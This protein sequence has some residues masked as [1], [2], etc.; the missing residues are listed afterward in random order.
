MAG[1]DDADE[2][3]RAAAKPAAESEKEAKN[4][5]AYYEALT[6]EI[7]AKET[8]EEDIHLRRVEHLLE[9]EAF[10]C[11]QRCEQYP[12]GSKERFW[13][14]VECQSGFALMFLW[15][16]L[17][18]LIGLAGI[19]LTWN[20][21]LAQFLQPGWLHALPG[22]ET[23]F[24]IISFTF[25]AGFIG[26]AAYSFC[27]LYMHIVF[28][29]GNAFTASDDQSSAKDRADESKEREQNN[30]SA[31]QNRRFLI[32][33]EQRRFSGESRTYWAFR[34]L[35]SGVGGVFSYL[36]F[37]LLTAIYT[38]NAGATA[39]PNIRA[40]VGTAFISGAFFGDFL[41]FLARKSKDLFKDKTIATSGGNITNPEPT[42][43]N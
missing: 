10:T 7:D 20:G 29:K 33:R 43:K 18:M 19:Y 32:R 12:K 25:F 31:S 39:A 11:K 40:F 8:A 3:K 26:G 27:A 21:S 4:T 15:Q 30:Y 38:S 13:C 14:G 34:P 1:I 37:D 5:V 9:D 42:P 28:P 17:C 16:A 41:K 35:L 23:T 22:S 24:R 36:L 2:F 6:D